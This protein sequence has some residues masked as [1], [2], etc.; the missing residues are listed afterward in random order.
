MKLFTVMA[1]LLSLTVSGGVFHVRAAQAAD[2]WK[3]IGEEVL[4]E[5]CAMAEQ[6][7]PENFRVDKGRG[8]AMGNAPDQCMAGE[9][10]GPGGMYPPSG[11]R[12]DENFR[13]HGMMPPE[14][15][16]S[17]FVKVLDLTDVQKKQIFT[18]V[19]DQREKTSSLMKK[20][21]ELH[22]QL[23]KAEQ[24]TSFDEKAM[25]AI[26]ARLADNEADMI[27]SRVDSRNRISA[28]LTPAQRDQVKKM[29][30]DAE[31]GPRPPAGP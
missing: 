26:T 2:P 10:P 18:I 29:D 30:P 13:P 19:L 12:G 20:R 17:C 9:L 8:P 22:M 4:H 28:V 23:R 14:G 24:A 15:L 7:L 25:R 6:W 16:Q 21:A 5:N 3:M 1:V 31:P 27:V 11:R